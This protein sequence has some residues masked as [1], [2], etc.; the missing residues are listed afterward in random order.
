MINELWKHD[1]QNKN[2]LE[3]ADAAG[4]LY[5]KF[6]A[7]YKDLDSISQAMDKVSNNFNAAKGKLYTGRG[8]LVG[9]VEKLR[10]LGVKTK[11]NLD[12]VSQTTID[13][14]DETKTNENED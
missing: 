11:K 7:F 14:K 2:S 8:N 10:T 6:V 9:R 3:I 5:D 13:L 1:A 4:N 12:V